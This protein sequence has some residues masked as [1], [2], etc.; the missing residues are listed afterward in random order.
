MGFNT[1]PPQPFPP[2]SEGGQG[3]IEEIK[4]EL[5]EVQ[6]DISDL[7]TDVGNLNTTKVNQITIAPTFNT[8]DEYTVGD[9]VYYNGLSYRCVNAHTGE[10]DASDFIPTTI[11]LELESKSV[12]DYL[13]TE[14]NTGQKWIDGKDIYIIT[15]PLSN[16]ITINEGQWGATPLS[17]AN[18]DTITAVV[19]K[20]GK[21]VFGGIGAAIA[22]GYV[23]LMNN[24]GGS[25]S[26]D[27]FTI[28][29]TKSTT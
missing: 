10:W 8:E 27:N 26:I 7:N 15:V 18:I 9:I 12:I 6:E 23:N 22:E 14:Q 4:E 17:A 1:F 20:S 19:A 11:A 21:F 5:T 2:N 29:Y 24:S 28:W 16:S 13:I 25:L 3:A